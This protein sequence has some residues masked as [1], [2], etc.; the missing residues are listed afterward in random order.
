MLGKSNYILPWWF[1][2]DQSTLTNLKFENRLDSIFCHTFIGNCVV[3]IMMNSLALNHITSWHSL[4]VRWLLVHACLTAQASLGTES[5]NLAPFLVF[6]RKAVTQ[7]CTKLGYSTY[8]IHFHSY[9]AFQAISI[10]LQAI[11]SL[12]SAIQPFLALLNPYQLLD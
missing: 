1:N 7:L 3:I 2:G 11:S 12:F 8:V 9:Q 10:N 4:C 5:Q 6:L